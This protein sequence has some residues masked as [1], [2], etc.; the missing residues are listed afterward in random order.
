MLNWMQTTQLNKQKS[1]CWTLLAQIALACLGVCLLLGLLN[2]G[3]VSAQSPATYTVQPGDTLGVIATRLGVGLDA[4]AAANG[5]VDVNVIEVGQ[6]LVIPGGES[7]GGVP[8]WPG[9]TLDELA[10]RLGTTAEQ[11]AALN[12]MEVSARLFP[13][14]PVQI[15]PD[16]TG[17]T[18][19][20]F[21]A[22]VHVRL[23]SQ[24]VQGRTGRLAVE[25]SRPLSLTAAWNSLPLGIQPA[26]GSDGSQQFAFLP[27]PALLGPGF[28]PVEIGYVSGSGAVI[29]RTFSV[30]V[31]E[32]PY[33]SQLIELPDDK[34]GLL[35]PEFTQPEIEKLYALWAVADEPLRWTLPFSRPIG[36]EF[37]TT[38]P[39]GTRR[40]YNGG[41]YSSYHS[42]QDFG[43]PEGITVTAPG[44]G[45]VVLAEPLNVRGN[46]VVIDH[47]AG[48]FTGYWHLSENFVTAGQ[49]VTVGDAL[50]LVGTTGLSTGNHLHWEVRIYGVSVDPLQFLEEGIGDW[51]TGSGN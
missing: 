33:D 38:S 25:S 1:P 46:A 9:E 20:R 18:T 40:S 13:G 47:G 34:G 37:P 15:P 29:S 23:P 42:G 17:D 41:P 49:A 22:V 36:L 51:G 5:I 35:D 32:G 12:Q 24:I 10:A 48:V 19:L 8:A 16:A 4:L 44:D 2:P 30:L 14:Q 11:L 39:Y 27:T 3:T 45:I 26:P 21:G 43:A 28:F 31:S 50:G 7:G 6:V